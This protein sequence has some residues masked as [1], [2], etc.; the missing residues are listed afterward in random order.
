MTR[1]DDAGQLTLLVIGYV[2][3]AAVLVVVGID[4]SAAFLARRA[5]ASV[6]DSAALAGAQAVDRQAYYAGVG[7]GVGCG[8]ALPVDPAS[9]SQRVAGIVADDAVDLR[10]MFR[11]IDPPDVR[12]LA[13]TVTVRLHG[14]AGVPFARVLAWLA[15][16]HG[17]G[18]V[19][20]DVTAHARSALST[21]G[22]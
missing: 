11:T 1:R 18:A 2:A 17:D 10:R 14:R 6:A 22:C 3:I 4:V 5:L 15:P 13:G 16:G 12:V 20:I 8:V 7:A 19:D 21:A 9:A